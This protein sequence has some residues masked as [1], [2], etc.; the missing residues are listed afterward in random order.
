M[1]TQE[2]P[3]FGKLRGE[4]YRRRRSKP[5]KSPCLP[6]LR[7][8]PPTYPVQQWCLD[9]HD[10]QP[11]RPSITQILFIPAVQSSIF[12]QQSSAATFLQLESRRWH[13]ALAAVSSG[14]ILRVR[15]N[16]GAGWVLHDGGTNTPRRS[17]AN[18]LGGLRREGG[19]VRATRTTCRWRIAVKIGVKIAAKFEFKMHWYFPFFPRTLGC[20]PCLHTSPR[21]ALWIWTS[22][23]DSF[24]N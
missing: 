1:E 21:N 22:D 3:K 6:R 8:K 12:V 5:R 14:N 11:V 15:G 13:Q 2:D 20:E 7:W 9:P 16:P 24:G 4:V 10:R 19:G 18:K 23:W 17:S